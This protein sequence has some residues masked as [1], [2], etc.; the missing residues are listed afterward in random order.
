MPTRIARAPVARDEPVSYKIQVQGR[1][2]QTWADYLGGMAV[3]ISSEGE[4][5]VTTLSGQAVDQGLLNS[6]YDLGLLLLS[7]ENQ[8]DPWEEVTRD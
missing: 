8:S 4:R 7:V 3:S 6:L 2:S 5:T 1:L